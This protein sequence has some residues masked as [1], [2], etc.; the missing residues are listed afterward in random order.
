MGLGTDSMEPVNVA[1]VGEWWQK[2]DQSFAVGTHHTGFPISQFFG[3]LLIGAILAV[4]TWRT[5]FF[6]IPLVA[7]PIMVVR[8]V[9]AKR[10]RKLCRARRQAA[11][12][13]GA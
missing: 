11:N 1:M 9:L 6:F 8:L 5:A 12:R 2:D 13:R 4:D 7:L 3:P 10:R